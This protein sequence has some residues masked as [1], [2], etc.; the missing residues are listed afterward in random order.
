MAKHAKEI[1]QRLHELMRKNGGGAITLSWPDYYDLS[2][3][4]RIKD[5][6][7]EAVETEALAE[8]QIIVRHAPAAVIVCPNAN[9]NPVKP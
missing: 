4:E 2:E 3:R 1:A 5:A 6:F 7:V 9:F 8:Y